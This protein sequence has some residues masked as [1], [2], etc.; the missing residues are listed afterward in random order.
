[1]KH[2]LV[3]S[4]L[5]AAM[6]SAA[7]LPTSAS[8]CT[9]MLWNTDSDFVMVG[10]NEDYFSASA[11]TLV[12]T[13][14]GIER[15]GSVNQQDNVAEWKVKYGS[16]V[17]FANNRFAMDGINEQGLTARTLYFDQGET[18]EHQSDNNKPVL[19]GDHWVSYVLDNFST[20]SDALEGLEGLRLVSVKG[21]YSYSASPKHMSIADSTG[22]SAIIEIQDGEVKV[23]HGEQYRV[24]TNPPN[25]QTQVEQASKRKIDANDGTFPNTFS[26]SDRYQKAQ[27]WLENFPKVKSTDDINAAYGFMYSALGTTAFV[28]GTPLPA[29]DAAVGKEIMKHTQSE[30]SYGVGTYFQSISDLTNK[31]YRFK[32]LLA[33]SDVYVNLSDI[34]WK[35]EKTVEVIPRI[36]RHAQAG[37][38]GDIIGDF[39]AI[40]ENDIYEQPI[41]K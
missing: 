13:P 39:Q 6:T 21:G 41:V 7:L 32:S 24:M 30:D 11:P 9:R 35:K 25:I 29:E 15:K 23:F 38:Q 28:P 2:K 40:E 17:S 36:D 10:R 4:C 27:Y 5:A 8:A 18:D 37:L 3:I 16:I 12:K 33:P 14:R 1:M 20:V 34:D 22:D 31:V 26:G 19:E